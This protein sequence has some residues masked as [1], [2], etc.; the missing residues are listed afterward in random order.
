M[1]SRANIGKL[2]CMRSL[3]L[4]FVVSLFPAHAI[5]ATGD[6]SAAPKNDE[7]V[8]Q[9][10]SKPQTENS[11]IQQ[12]VARN[13]ADGVLAVNDVF[14]PMSGLSWLQRLARQTDTLNYEVSFVQ[15]GMKMSECLTLC[16]ISKSLFLE[17]MNYI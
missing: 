6:P 5:Q 9:V 15:A 16:E 17:Q 4:F 2:L 8:Q 3:L 13:V 11:E 14:D 10:K 12:G 7:T 1:S